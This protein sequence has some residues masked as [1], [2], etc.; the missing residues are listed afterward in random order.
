LKEHGV[1]GGTASSYIIIAMSVEYVCQW[2]RDDITILLLDMK[3][4]VK[5]ILITSGDNVTSLRDDK[6]P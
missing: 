3:R 2:L 1:T 6:L 4:D 5:C